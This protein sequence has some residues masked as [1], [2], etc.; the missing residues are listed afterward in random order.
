MDE[1]QSIRNSVVISV[2]RLVSLCIVSAGSLGIGFLGRRMAMSLCPYFTVVV[3][4]AVTVAVVVVAAAA[5]AAAVFGFY[6]ALNI[7]GY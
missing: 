7:S 1:L 5:A 4:A 3:G 2:I 6:D